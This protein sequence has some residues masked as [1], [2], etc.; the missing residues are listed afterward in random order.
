MYYQIQMSYNDFKDLM[1]EANIHKSITP[2]YLILYYKYKH[3]DPPIF[4]ICESWDFEKDE[5]FITKVE[6]SQ[7]ESHLRNLEVDGDRT[8]IG[9][10]ARPR[11]R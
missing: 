8:L 1:Q 9:L 4:F 5:A 3:D 10:T 11:Q 6:R 2:P 7:I